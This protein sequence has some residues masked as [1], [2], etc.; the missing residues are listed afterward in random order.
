MSKAISK[1][2][3]LLCEQEKQPHLPHNILFLL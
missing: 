3:G 2:T 1:E